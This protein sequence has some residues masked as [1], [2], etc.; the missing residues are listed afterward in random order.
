MYIGI[1]V[2]GT[3]L[4]AGVVNGENEIIS[5]AKVK[6]AEC[7]GAEHMTQELARAFPAR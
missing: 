2:G 6:T 4:V 5:R 7:H 3:N 1:D